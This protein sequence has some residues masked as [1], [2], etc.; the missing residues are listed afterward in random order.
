MLSII[1]PFYNTRKEL[2]NRLI[3]ILENQNDKEFEW[4]IID[5]C[6]DE[7]IANEFEK[8]LKHVDINYIYVKNNVNKGAA[9]SRNRGMKIA[10]GEYCVFV[11]SDDYITKDFVKVIN[12]HT[13]NTELDMFVF[14]YYTENNGTKTAKHT[15]NSYSSGPLL[16][17]DVLISI[18]SNVCGK[19]V[20]RDVIENNSIVF[21]DLNRF[22]DW[23][24]MTKCISFSD[25]IFY[26][27]IPLYIYVNNQES[28]V[29]RFSQNSSGYAKTAFEEIE[30]TNLIEEKVLE[31]LYIREVLYSTVK[32]SISNS[33]NREYKKNIIDVES[34]YTNWKN[35]EYL[36]LFPRNQKIILALYRHKLLWPLKAI[37]KL[38]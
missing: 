18:T 17:N 37:M 28:V 5:D 7:L 35:N 14:D 30:N 8:D 4:I 16:R 1:T 12:T 19:V 24:F 32:E 26:K 21:P 23:V 9:F 3:N 13:K 29:H 11:D 20:K 27:T 33:A 36:K 31:A 25:R 38:L 6:S 22:E 2:F 10:T 15:I 34:K